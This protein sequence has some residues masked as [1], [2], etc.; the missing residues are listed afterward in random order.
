MPEPPPRSVPL[1]AMLRRLSGVLATALVSCLCAGEELLGASVPGAPHA[2]ED[3]DECLSA[4]QV[5]KGKE[6]S[7]QHARV[8]QRDGHTSAE[9]LTHST[10][11][12]SPCSWHKIEGYFCNLIN[13]TTI[14]TLEYAKWSCA[15]DAACGGVYYHSGQPWAGADVGKYY[16]CKKEPATYD[17]LAFAN[18]EWVYG[19]DLTYCP[20]GPSSTACTW[21]SQEILGSALPKQAVL[22]S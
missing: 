14:D 5:S 2:D 21:Y 10:P 17:G 16:L 13:Y 11:P 7:E 15:C 12:P 18:V 19:A 6:L 8:T 4:L 22:R 20:G 1:A 3:G 9:N